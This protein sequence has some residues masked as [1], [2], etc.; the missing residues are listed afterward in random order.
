MLNDTTKLTKLK[1][2]PVSQL[3]KNKTNESR[4]NNVSSLKRKKPQLNI[5]LNVKIKFISHAQP[6]YITS[7]HTFIPIS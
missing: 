7:H 6:Y 4:M 3:K 5:I 2:N 1:K